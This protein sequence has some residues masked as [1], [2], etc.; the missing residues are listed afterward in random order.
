MKSGVIYRNVMK[1]ILEKR[2]KGPLGAHEI[3]DSGREGQE[4]AGNM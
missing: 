2:I 1:Q 3:W 4:E